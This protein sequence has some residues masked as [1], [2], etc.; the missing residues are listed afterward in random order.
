MA[1]TASPETAPIP[2]AA[3]SPAVTT[4]ASPAPGT[5]GSTTATTMLGATARI[6]TVDAL[7]DMDLVGAD[8]KGIGDIEGVVENN[9]DKK[10]FVVIER[11][12]FLG[13]GAK[14]IT[15]P[16]ENL[17]VQS[18][19]VTLHNMDVAQLDGLAEFRNDSNAFRDLDD[20]HQISVPQQ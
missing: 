1:Q 15:L 8:E 11:G 19:R 7:E 12:G 10:Q 20:S 4:P 13:F 9:T 5:T 17:A 18:E 2:P 16:L 3:A 14:T 6:L